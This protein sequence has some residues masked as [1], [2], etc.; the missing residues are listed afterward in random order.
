MQLSSEAVNLQS[1]AQKLQGHKQLQRLKKLVY[2]TSTGNWE[3]DANILN[4]LSLEKLLEQLYQSNSSLEEL[5]EALY[6]SVDTLNRQTVYSELANL[7]IAKIGVMYQDSAGS[8]EVIMIKPSVRDNIS[9]DVIGKIVIKFNKHPEVAR[10]KKLI[11]YLAK[12]QWENDVNVIDSYGLKELIL[13]IRESYPNFGDV[14]QAFSDLVA[15]LNRQHIYL[16]VSEAITQ[17]LIKLYKS[18]EG[19]TSLF[20][21]KTGLVTQVKPKESEDKI[22]TIQEKTTEIIARQTILQENI[23]ETSAKEEEVK[24]KGMVTYTPFDWR[25]DIMQY[26]NPL[27]VK[28]LMFCLLYHQFQNNEKDWSKL[29]SCTLEDLLT[30]VLNRYDSVNQ[31]ENKLET[32]YKQSTE[33]EL[34]QQTAAVLIKSLMSFYENKI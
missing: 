19:E 8:T 34:Y 30:K 1:V 32:I 25:L 12:D 27:R 33:P 5:S 17:E 26:T 4:D 10:I 24:G 31:V 23:T 9:E 21:N 29:K 6:Q 20:S 14:E 3:N 13:N 16:A 22:T 18:E 15:T 28:I 7:V 11:F 2:Y